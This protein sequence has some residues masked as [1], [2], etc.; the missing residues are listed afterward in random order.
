MASPLLSNPGEPPLA[1]FSK[2]VLLTIEVGATPPQAPDERFKIPPP[3]IPPDAGVVGDGAILYGQ[4][5]Q[6][7]KMPPP[8]CGAFR[9]P[10]FL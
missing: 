10:R 1:R 4:C 3:A 7:L 9:R 8:S 6:S 5:T 2:I